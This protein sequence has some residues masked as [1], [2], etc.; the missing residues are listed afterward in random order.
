[1][2]RDTGVIGDRLLFLA[3]KDKYI[4]GPTTQEGTKGTKW[5]QGK[6]FTFM[7]KIDYVISVKYKA[8]ATQK[9]RIRI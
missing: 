8:Q 7:G 4:E 6:C 2:K 3:G 1:M 9:L 5:I